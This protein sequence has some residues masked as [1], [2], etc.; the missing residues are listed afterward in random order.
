[1]SEDSVATVSNHV[2]QERILDIITTTNVLQLHEQVAT[3]DD[4]TIVTVIVGC[5][6]V[7]A[8]RVRTKGG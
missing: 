1:M 5:T 7:V 4:M 6:W 2:K 8:T 3:K